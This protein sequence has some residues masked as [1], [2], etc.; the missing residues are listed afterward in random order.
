MLLHKSLDANELHFSKLTAKI[1]REKCIGG[2]EMLKL[3]L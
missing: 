1:K 2:L 3:G